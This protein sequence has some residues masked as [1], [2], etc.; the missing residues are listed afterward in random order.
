[1]TQTDSGAITEKLAFGCV[2]C[3]GDERASDRPEIG[4]RALRCVG[5]GDLFD[6]FHRIAQPA[7][8]GRDVEDRLDL[9]FDRLVF[10]RLPNPVGVPH[11]HVRLVPQVVPN[12]PTEQAQAALASAILGHV[13]HLG[14]DAPIPV[15]AG[16]T[17]V[18]ADPPELPVRPFDLPMEGLRLAVRGALDQ[19]VRL[20]L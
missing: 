18:D 10:Y 16:R 5:F 11:D 7:H 4:L 12:D 2:S 3:V 1:M 6:L 13:L 20:V 14:D 9:L 19:P 15:D 8:L 17:E